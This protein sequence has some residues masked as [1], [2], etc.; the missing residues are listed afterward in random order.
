MMKS[1]KIPEGVK[2]LVTDVAGNYGNSDITKTSKE[3]VFCKKCAISNQRPRITFDE[4][5]VCS[6]CQYGEVKETQIDWDERHK[7]LLDLLDQYRR[8][9][10][11]YDCLVPVSGGKDSCFVAHQLKYEYNMN[12]LLVT[13]APL[14][15]T[16]VG[17]RNL[18]ALIDTGFDCEI[19]VPNTYAYRLLSRLSTEY[20]GDPFQAFVYGV[21]AYPVRMALKYNIPLVFYGENGE[22]EYGGDMKNSNTFMHDVGDDLRKHYF[23]G[24]MPSEWTKYGVDKD[25][26][27]PFS[28]PNPDQVQEKQIKCTWYSFFKKWTPQWNYYYAQEHTGFEPEPD[29][30]SEGTYSKYASIDDKF[31][32][33]HFYMAYLKF[34]IGRATSDASH[35]VRDGHIER[36]EAVA[37]VRKYDGEFPKKYYKDF[38]EYMDFTDEDF[39]RI[40][41]SFRPE[42]LWDK[43]N[44]EWKLRCQV[45]NQ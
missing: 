10:G 17:W 29:G 24:M 42:H 31:D 13:F 22:V 30:R 16:D 45:T 19:C 6:A 1:L 44:G 20:L 12:P 40:S 18:Q 8:N 25:L 39:Q 32:G 33:Y 43:V 7:N 3:V 38:L 35:E 37:L 36:E 27:A 34:G 21:K 15:W 5:G 28:L 9:D 11:Y 4:N 23:K 41:D 14:R 2:E 26:L